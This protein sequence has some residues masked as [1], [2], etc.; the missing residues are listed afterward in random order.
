MGEHQLMHTVLSP[1]QYLDDISK[2]L[3]CLISSTYEPVL[4][5]LAQ[6]GVSQNKIFYYY[7]FF[8]TNNKLS[9]YKKLQI[10]GFFDITSIGRATLAKRTQ[11]L[12][13]KGK[14]RTFIIKSRNKITG[15]NFFKFV[16]RKNYFSFYK[17]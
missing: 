13:R 12:K 1:A 11:K 2:C 14:N 15:V 4:V 9:A 17:Q 7:S 10:Q 8:T 16:P 6:I 5:S 3:E